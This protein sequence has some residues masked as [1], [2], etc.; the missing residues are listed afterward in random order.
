M[1]PM[2]P[3][4]R[5]VADQYQALGV[6]RLVLLPNPDAS[7]GRRH[8]PVPVDDIL[9]TIDRTANMIRTP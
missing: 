6:D 7:A 8:E 3:F 9:R 4:D 5:S 1:T 2:G